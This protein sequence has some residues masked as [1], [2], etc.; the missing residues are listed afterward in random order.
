M[1]DRNMKEL[2]NRES[3]LEEYFRHAIYKSQKECLAR[4]L[5]L[6]ESHA[7][8]EKLENMDINIWRLDFLTRWKLYKFWLLKLYRKVMKKLTSLEAIFQRKAKALQEV[9]DQEFLH[10]MRHHSIVGMTTTGA[11]QYSA[12]MQDLAPAIGKTCLL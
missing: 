5:N 1:L 10:I 4:G 7:E 9:K 11:A 12:V 3:D 6:P 8:M 2:V